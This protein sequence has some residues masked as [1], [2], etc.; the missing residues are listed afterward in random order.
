LC[1]SEAKR[2]G[3]GGNR[4]QTHPCGGKSDTRVIN[5]LIRRCI[6]TYGRNVE[7]YISN[8]R[9][10]RSPVDHEAGDGVAKMCGI[11]LIDIGTGAFADGTVGICSSHGA[12]ARRSGSGLHF[13]KFITP[14]NRIGICN[15]HRHLL[16]NS[17]GIGRSAPRECN[18]NVTGL[19]A[20]TMATGAGRF[21][22]CSGTS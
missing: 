8:I 2:G 6:A 20:S 1:I 22:W 12:G 10:R 15:C 9:S 14:D 13:G 18:R 19:V 7:D 17:R 5:R 11:V 21:T 4:R 3:S 16:L